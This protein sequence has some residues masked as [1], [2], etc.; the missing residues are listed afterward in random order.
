MQQPALYGSR[1]RVL[2][3]LAAIR[4]SIM[5]QARDGAQGGVEAFRTALRRLFVGFELVPAGVWPVAS[6]GGVIRPQDEEHPEL[7]LDGYQLWPHVRADAFDLDAWEPHKT[8]LGFG[9]LGASD[10]ASAG[11]A[12]IQRANTAL[13]ELNDI[14][15]L[16]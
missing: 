15:L 13:S 9:A 5:G 14:G 12:G 1:C 6:I 7:D 11:A 2:A 8:A 10:T 4:A 3:A 16:M